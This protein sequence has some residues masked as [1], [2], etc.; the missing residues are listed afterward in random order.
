MGR[1]DFIMGADNG[2]K[3]SFNSFF[4]FIMF[5]LNF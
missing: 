2:A 5:N 1:A 4:A 3:E